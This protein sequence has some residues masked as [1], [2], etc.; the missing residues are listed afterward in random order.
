M[1]DMTYSEA[2]DNANHLI[3]LGQT[4]VYLRD[5]REFPFDKATD[6]ASGSSYRLSGPS[7][8][9]IIA[10]DEGL[11]FKLNIEF[12]GRDANGKGV[13]LF[14]RD[15]LRELMMKLPAPARKK[16]AGMLAGEVL[17]GMMKRTQE[18][19]EALRAQADSE[20]CVRGLIAF[21]EQPA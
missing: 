18:I 21:A 17:S 11:Q 10:H 2:I 12:E 8:A 4:T 5:E 7:S 13:S 6:V 1:F 9:Y 20:D 3:A 14:D 16:F 15:R 19:R